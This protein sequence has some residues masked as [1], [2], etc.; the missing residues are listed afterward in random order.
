MP[1]GRN[2]RWFACVDL[3]SRNFLQMWGSGFLEIPVAQ[4][5][6]FW[7]ITFPKFDMLHLKIIPLKRKK[8]NLPSISAY[9]FKIW[10]VWNVWSIAHL[11]I[12]P[13]DITPGVIDVGN[14]PLIFREIQ[15]QLGPF[16]GEIGPKINGQKNPW[17]C[18]W[19][20][21]TLI[22]R[23]VTL[24]VPGRG[25][26]CRWMMIIQPEKFMGIST[27]PPR[28]FARISWHFPTV[29]MAIS[30]GFHG[31]LWGFQMAC[32]RFL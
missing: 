10:N 13:N 23:V 19:G 4:H 27:T 14:E 28:N 20:C 1:N 29:F 12:V 17:V 9:G 26:P 16:R 22:S 7:K 21:F 6:C 25:L 15:V 30:C 11:Q 18:H 3:F 32:P 8:T 5:L 24:L 2:T 31:M